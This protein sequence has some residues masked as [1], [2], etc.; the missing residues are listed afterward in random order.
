[1]FRALFSILDTIKSD[2]NLTMWVLCT[3]NGIL[4]D[5]RSHVN[6]I[7]HNQKSMSKQVDAIGILYRFLQDQLI[8][9]N[10]DKCELAA[11]SLSIIIQAHKNA[12]ITE[13][14]N[15]LDFMTW[16]LED[17]NKKLLSDKCRTACLVQ[18]MKNNK[19]AYIF[20]EKRNGFHKLQGW[21]VDCIKNKQDQLAYNTLA[22]LW[23]VSF[24]DFS[25]EYFRDF[26][27]MILENVSKV[28]DYYNKEKIVRVTLM[29]FEVSSFL[30]VTHDCVRR[31]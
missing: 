15:S 5:Q 13:M 14:Q 18:L 23:I 17:N 24:H 16:L 19:L 28:L 27:L 4:E 29:L 3:I 10:V 12:S 30:L 7:I 2:K 20:V 9:E 6:Q 21:L 11:H 25:L 26:K 1:M 22:I 8:E 31:A